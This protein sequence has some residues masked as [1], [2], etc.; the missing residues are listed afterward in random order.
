VIIIFKLSYIPYHHG[1]IIVNVKASSDSWNKLNGIITGYSS[2]D[3]RILYVLQNKV[4]MY[5][6][7]C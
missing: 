1:T 2:N 6:L 7:N 5:I 3:I 4:T